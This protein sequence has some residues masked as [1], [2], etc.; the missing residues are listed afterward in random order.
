[1][2]TSKFLDDDFILT[3]SDNEDLPPSDET[4][5]EPEVD[6][7]GSIPQG[8]KRK[9]NESENYVHKDEGK[10]QRTERESQIR[11]RESPG[12]SSISEEQGEND[13]TINPEFEFDF[14]IQNHSTDVLDDFDGWGA[15]SRQRDL[16]NERRKRKGVDIDEIITR[17]AAKKAAKSMQ[18]Q[19]N[20]KDD[21]VQLHDSTSSAEEED[22]ADESDISLA[23]NGIPAFDDDEL[24]ADDGFGAGARSEDEISAQ[25]SLP[26][27]S[28][29]DH[30]AASQASEDEDGRSDSDSIASPTAHPDDLASGS[31][32]SESESSIEDPEEM[33]KRKAFFASESNVVSTNSTTHQKG[34]NAFTA[35][36]LSRPLL[37]ALT[38]L[39]FSTPTPIQTRTIPIALAGHDVVGSAVTGSGKTAAFLLPILERLL[40]RPRRVPTTRVAIMVPTRELAVQCHAVATQLAK[41]TDI[42]FAL[43]VGGFSLRE[44]ESV[45][46][47]RPDVVIA[48]PGRFID[49]MR[50]SAS[51]AVE[52][53]EIL[54]LDEA[55]RMLE[56]G[57]ADELDEILKTLPRSRQT[58]LFSATMTERIDRLVRLGMNKP[59]RVSVD[60]R[61]ATTG[62]LVQE[63]VRLRPGREDK[64]L[65]TLAV[66][67]TQTFRERTIVFFRQKREAHRVRVVFG[68][69][70]VKAGELHGSMTQ[71]QRI[72]AVTAF[73]DGR[74]THLLATDLASR[75]LDI[76]NVATVVNYEAPAS[77][78]LYVHRVGRTARAG[79][80]GKSCTIAAESD[81]K[82]V[83]A[84][85][86]TARAQ[87]ARVVSRTLDLAAVD[88]MYDTIT[89][90]AEE[91]DEI[92]RE[93]KEERQLAQVEGEIRR[94]ENLVTHRD[95]ILSRPRR[96]WFEGP[97][98]K[99]LAKMRG[100]QELNGAAADDFTKQQQAGGKTTKTKLSGKDKKR[101]DDRRER[102]EGKVWRKGK[103]SEMASREVRRSEKKNK[104][105][106]R[107]AKTSQG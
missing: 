103:G 35:F 59:V 51:F 29:D 6:V 82:V 90:L 74:T 17:R 50:N 8:R 15:S 61:K 36:S 65:A 43:L 89:N 76:R 49:H 83:K 73:R 53:V 101:L 106:K 37:R 33:A 38:S 1:M 41:Y 52:H 11:K 63:F 99:M 10:K 96:T 32:D 55:D 66:L 58:M 31:S 81:R 7:A 25:G 23:D 2:S 79:R 72:A 21:G 105:K 27:D 107:K 71:D 100:R 75:G 34:S 77:H 3:I 40:Y 87:G 64:R 19:D 94:G 98:E 30:K 85:V 88:A 54:V 70:G 22:A 14:G 84:A 68:L 91:V 13:G 104:R 80:E 39:A 67:C 26:M 57:F 16:E 9:R 5:S 62:G 78:E 48:T 95:E 45:L 4:T 102:M 86:K 12:A 97:R 44:Q 24:L 56:D 60:K 92:L 20:E 47:K 42:T 69:L 93:E 46:K 28:E 18:M